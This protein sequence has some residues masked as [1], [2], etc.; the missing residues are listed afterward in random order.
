MPVLPAS[1]SRLASRGLKGD[2]SGRQAPQLS[3]RVRGDRPRLAT[4][5]PHPKG[6][7]ECPGPPCS[8]GPSPGLSSSF[9][10][11]C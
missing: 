10:V 3:S 9:K 2:S 1:P 11:T 6:W 4:G 8:P 7:D 5:C